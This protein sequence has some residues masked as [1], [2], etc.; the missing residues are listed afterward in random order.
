MKTT[1]L[2]TEPDVPVRRYAAMIMIQAINDSAS[3]IVVEMT[4]EPCVAIDG[5]LLAQPPDHLMN[6]LIAAY[7]KMAGCIRWRWTTREKGRRFC[8]IYDGIS[9][10]WV[11]SSEDIRRVVK[12]R[13]LSDH[14]K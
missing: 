14:S 11:L 3:E 5:S 4:D 9:Y 2:H 6:H 1:R 12:I 13:R 7:L 8:T 10:L